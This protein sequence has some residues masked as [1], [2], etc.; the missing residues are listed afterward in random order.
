M[1]EDALSALNTGVI[2]CRIEDTPESA[3]SEMLVK[4]IALL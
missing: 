4:T 2:E 3:K 1:E